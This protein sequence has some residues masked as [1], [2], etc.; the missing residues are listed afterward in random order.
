MVVCNKGSLPCEM[1]TENRIL[2]QRLFI[3]SIIRSDGTGREYNKKT[4]TA[5]DVGE[6][7]IN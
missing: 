2:D 7:L 4:C 6:D 5:S 3:S 1:I